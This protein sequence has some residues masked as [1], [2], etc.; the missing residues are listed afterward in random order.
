MTVVEESDDEGSGDGTIDG[1]GGTG[2][3]MAQ[4]RRS[5]CPFTRDLWGHSES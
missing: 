2:L 1:G 5:S 4:G 3:S